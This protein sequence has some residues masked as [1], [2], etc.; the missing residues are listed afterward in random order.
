[1]LDNQ[2]YILP[3]PYNQLIHSCWQV[4]RYVPMQKE[5]IIPKGVVEIIFN[6]S[7]GENINARIN[8][9]E[10]QLPK[11]FINGFNKNPI[12]LEFS[13]E[14]FFFGMSFQPLAIKKILKVPAGEFSGM[15]VDLGLIEPSFNLLWGR[16]GEAISFEKR[17][18]II[19]TWAGKYLIDWQPQEKMINQF[20]SGNSGHDISVTKLAN[21]LCYSPRQLCRK[22]NEAT[23][24]STEDI[25]L[26]KKYLHALNLVHNSN[27]S[28]TEIAYESNFSDQ[29]HLIRSFRAFTNLT[30]GEYKRSKSEVKG[31]IYNNV[32]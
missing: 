23:G 29:S 7:S 1:M 3:V 12:L 27:L 17:V 18:E 30:P 11:C 14:Q 10:N 21:E 2:F 16:L 4:K 31:H 20:L 9:N 28:L 26:Y 25:L 6:F 5:Y 15:I 13:E 19:T 24:M 22:F 8:N 32:R